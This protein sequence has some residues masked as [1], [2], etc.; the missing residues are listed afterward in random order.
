MT[1][2][3]NDGVVSVSAQRGAVG[4]RIAGAL[5]LAVGVLMAAASVLELGHR[6]IHG[7]GW[8]LFAWKLVDY[9]NAHA[10]SRSEF[11]V[12]GAAFEVAAALATLSGVLLIAGLGVRRPGVRWFGTFAAGSVIAVALAIS[13]SVASYDGV[14]Y[15]FGFWLLVLAFFG[16]IAAIAAAIRE[17]ANGSP[18]GAGGVADRVSATFLVLAALLTFSSEALTLKSAIDQGYPLHVNAAIALPVITGVVGCVIAGLLFMGRG[19]TSPVI[20]M[21]G[22]ST[23]GIVF[24]IALTH[25]LFK[26]SGTGFLSAL[27]ATPIGYFIMLL[28]VI[29]S[30]AATIASLV[31]HLAAP[32][33]QAPGFPGYAP[34]FMPPPVAMPVSAP[35]PFA[36]AMPTPNPFAPASP[37]PNPFAPAPNVEATVKLPPQ[38]PRMAKVYDG[39]DG[40]GR[41]VV[42]R[43][44][45]EG[46]VR[47]AVLAYLESAPVVL[48]ARS[49]EQD[50]FVPADRDV[51]LNFRTDGTWV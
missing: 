20:R 48:A 19:V 47:T 46:N 13:T 30:I 42:E 44:V 28:A 50:E 29:V 7:N 37:A 22:S 11:L 16:A 24:G 8:Q 12:V 25:A 23:A 27:D 43:P 39:K 2:R 41:P 45:L 1:Y 14:S 33:L 38:P 3:Q 35:N 32:R 4:W 10:Q 34:G 36:P 17:T 26:K 49:F 51:P 9:F 21:L 31:A 18:N 15:G 40:E 5:L 6:W